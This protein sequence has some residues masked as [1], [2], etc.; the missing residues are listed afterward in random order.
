MWRERGVEDGGFGWMGLVGQKKVRQASKRLVKRAVSPKRF[1]VRRARLRLATTRRS[2][3]GCSPKKS[4]TRA[5]G[6]K[7]SSKGAG[8]QK[9]KGML[10]SMSLKGKCERTLLG[11]TVCAAFQL[12]MVEGL[13]R[14]RH[15]LSFFGVRA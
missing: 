12:M 4:R 2:N 6:L 3:A 8:A 9:E 14:A 11:R 1:E 13:P 15:S 10:G 7:A 5:Q